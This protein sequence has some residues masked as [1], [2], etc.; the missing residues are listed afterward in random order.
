MSFLSLSFWTHTDNNT[1]LLN[2]SPLRLCVSVS[3]S[4]AM[5]VFE[6]VGMFCW[7]TYSCAV[8]TI[9]GK[10]HRAV[11]GHTHTHNYLISFHTSTKPKQISLNTTQHHRLTSCLCIFSSLETPS[12][13]SVIFLSPLSARADDIKDENRSNLMHSNGVKWY[14]FMVNI[15]QQ[16]IR[17]LDSCPR[18]PIQMQN[19]C[20]VTEWNHICSQCTECIC[21]STRFWEHWHVKPLGTTH[22][23]FSILLINHQFVDISHIC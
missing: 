11:N 4:C 2:H 13:E 10:K 6:S 14:H 22:S 21:S 5:F 9:K 8:C 18:S 3:V 23:I 20:I 12:T 1:W 15:T 17:H 7:C 19:S 16:S